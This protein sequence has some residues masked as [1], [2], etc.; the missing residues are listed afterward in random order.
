V[1]GG[2]DLSETRDLTALVLVGIDI[3][4]GRLPVTLFDIRRFRLNKPENN[5]NAPSGHKN[6]DSRRF[7]ARSSD[8]T[9]SPQ[10]R[11][12][13]SQAYFSPAIWQSLGQR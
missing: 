9:P 12:E 10:V 13:Q 11:R 3:R 1:F 7:R 5:R 4:D 6:R 2:L 8:E